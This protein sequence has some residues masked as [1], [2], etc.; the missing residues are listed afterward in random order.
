MKA[1]ALGRIGTFRILI[2]LIFG[3]IFGVAAWD[4]YHIIG[5]IHKWS[6]PFS[7]AL[8]I[9]TILVMGMGFGGLILGLIYVWDHRWKNP[10]NSS[11]SRLRESL[12]WYR[13]PIVV[14]VAFTPAITISYT[15]FGF[16]WIGFGF[17]FVM[18]IVTVLLIT[19]L[20][21]SKKDTPFQW[22]GI[23]VSVILTG[24]IFVFLK[25]FTGVVNYP[26]SL[27]WSEGNRIWDYSIFFGRDLYNYPSDQPIKAYI[28]RGRQALW[29]LPFLLPNVTIFGVRM[30]SAIL[31]TIPYALL[32][33]M[34]F[35]PN[36]KYMNQ[37]VWLGLWSFLFL[38]QGPIYTPLILGGILVV[39]VRKKPIWFGVPLIFLAGYYVQK[40]RITWM[41]APMMWGVLIALLD[42][43]AQNGVR[44]LK[45]HWKTILFYGLAGFLGGFGILRGW[46]T[47]SNY[48]GE[49]FDSKATE[50]VNEPFIGD[51]VDTTDSVE[52]VSVMGQNNV[53]VDQ[54][55]LWER[56][57]PNP[58][59]GLGIILGLLLAVSPLVILL[60]YMVHNKH[61]RLNALQKL[62]L[63]GILSVLL[64]L[65]IV[66]STKI[67]G[68]GDLHNLDMF[69]ISLV[70]ASALAW[71]Y[72]GNRFLSN[73]ESKSLGFNLVVLFIV[74]IPA[75]MPWINAEPIE[76]PP[77]EKSQRTMDLLRKEISLVLEEGGE[78]L[79]MD[80]RQ[81]L[82]FGYL[83]DIPLVP[84]YEKKLVMDRAMSGDSSY[85]ELFYKD[86]SEQRFQLIITDPQRVRYS[87]DDEGWGMENNTWVEWVT[88]PLLCYYEP[89]YPIKTTGVW[90]LKPREDPGECN[91]P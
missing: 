18:F 75:F 35:Y 11:L 53:L 73:L 20:S 2:S 51:L 57:W 47:L 70:L 6:E 64:G 41:A 37:W 16:R 45:T 9:T 22:G 34:A 74:G 63:L 72:G 52:V 77:V 15:S 62:G 89:S 56:L 66:I 80:Q 55:L 28:D 44:F 71:E 90:L 54:P 40:S 42:N 23:L 61:W 30:W 79:F 83:G 13:W 36:R 39:G 67:G 49:M 81:L 25:A 76:L 24:S 8:L 12:G 82:T 21:S 14:I 88:K 59:Y 85:F 43:E 58:T 68:G 1:A 38:S 3:G 19:F 86:I 60:I 87:E 78:I 48:F 7:I 31:F 65:G 27:T 84:E 91:F 50:T 17:R 26:F 10:L 33:W 32:G 69:L 4:S 29:G 46:N 5:S